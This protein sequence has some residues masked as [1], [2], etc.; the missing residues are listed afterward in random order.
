M[1]PCAILLSVA[2]NTSRASSS[3]DLV[4]GLSNVKGVDLRTLCI[5]AA[6]LPKQE[7]WQDN[8]SRNQPYLAQ[9]RG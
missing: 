4:S 7:P 1:Q 8:A 9:G 6:V 5:S 3:V 2:S